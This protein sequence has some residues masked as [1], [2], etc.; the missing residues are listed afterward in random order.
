MAEGHLA[1]DFKKDCCVICQLGFENAEPVHV[2]KKGILTLLNY[3][4]KRGRDDLHIYLNRCVSTD[5]VEVVLV[6]Q[7][8]VGNLLTKQG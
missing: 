2:T 4:E 5:P 7:T 3:S 6:H 8:A 1:N